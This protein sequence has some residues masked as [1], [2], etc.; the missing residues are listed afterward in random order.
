MRPDGDDANDGSHD[1]PSNAFRTMQG[2]WSA[3]LRR[4]E[5]VD[6]V[7]IQ[8][9]DGVYHS[10]LSVSGKPSGT[11]GS[12]R[13]APV[14]VRGNEKDASRVVISTAGESCFEIS[15]GAV[16]AV[17]DL[18]IETRQSGNGFNVILNSTCYYSNI[19]F[20]DCAGFH[21]QCRHNSHM[22]NGIDYSGGSG[23]EI[24]GGAKLGH[25]HVTHRAAIINCNATVK[26]VGNPDFGTYF[27]GVS[28]GQADW[29]LGMSIEGEA[30][31]LRFTVLRNGVVR[32]P[33]GNGWDFFP[34][35]SDGIVTSGGQFLIGTDDGSPYPTVAS[36]GGKRVSH[37]GSREETVV[38]SIKVRKGS[39]GP[40]GF[41]R[42]TA[43]VSFDQSSSAK[44]FHLRWG[45]NQTIVASVRV[46]PL[47]SNRIRHRI[48]RRLKS[49]LPW[50]IKSDLPSRKTQV[51]RMTAEIWNSGSV[52]AQT[53]VLEQKMLPGGHA[54]RSIA[55]GSEDTS[56]PTGINITAKLDDP[57]E[58][59]TL[60]AWFAEVF[61]HK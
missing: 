45:Q 27:L 7:T 12:L 50:S 20:G 61:F 2:A 47:P 14:V 31:G 23:F 25:E 42:V 55:S 32:I 51:E 8:L 38:A 53:T 58:V 5:L 46:E 60:E 40:N 52:F 16:V 30:T 1:T 34:G 28:D 37:S 29:S 43:L 54:R 35:S 9:A 24:S 59:V 17:R 39:M 33:A 36:S 3:I 10:G 57:S 4:R 15:H 56:E 11:L 19:R 49:V 6:Q 41:L 21:K 48:L 44:L 26:V 22:F 13:H 18:T